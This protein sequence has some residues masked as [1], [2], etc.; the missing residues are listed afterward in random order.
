MDK[1]IVRVAEGHHV[2]YSEEISFQISKA[3]KERGTGI[4]LRSPEYLSEKILDGKAI[5]ALHGDRLAGFCYIETWEHNKYVANSGLI[6]LP[7]YRN[8]GLAGAIKEKAFELSKKKYPGA[9]L[10]GLTTSLAV[11]KINSKLGYTPVTLSQLTNDDEFWAG[12]KSCVNHDILVR[13]N[14]QHCLCTGMLYDPVKKNGKEVLKGRKLKTYGRWLS[15]K[16]QVLL[17]KLKKSKP[18]LIPKK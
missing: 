7:E 8:H 13:L 2:I 18:I 10:F 16:K 4:A 9:K 14:R 3:S 6:V 11:M 1:I 17:G 5:I 15:Y 12:C